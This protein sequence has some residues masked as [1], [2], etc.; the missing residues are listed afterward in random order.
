M[1]FNAHQYNRPVLVFGAGIQCSREQARAFAEKLGWP[2]ALTWGAIDLLPSSHELR[3][4]GFGTHALR[5]PNFAVQNADFL[6]CIGTRLDTKSTGTPAESF[7]RAADIWMVDIDVAEI[8]KFGQRVTGWNMDCRDFMNQFQSNQPVSAAWW[9][10][11]RR[12]VMR[13]PVSS[14]GPYQHVLALSERFN[15]GDIIVSDT[16]HALAWCMQAFQFK[17]NQRFIHAFNN[18]PMGYGLPAAIGAA[19]ANPGVPVRLITGDGGLQLNIQEW[20][21][22]AHHRLPITTYL[23]NNHGHGMCR[24]TQRQWMGGAFPSTSEQGGLACPDF[25]RIADAY[26]VALEEFILPFD[27]ELTPCV[28]SGRPNEDANPLIPR[29]ELESEMLIPLWKN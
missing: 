4:G 18:T 28:Q 2:V 10:A 11:I 21:T 27:S 7:A 23:F 26:G 16:G 20:S 25:R 13:W 12:W 14:F 24:Q 17:E 9:A 29:D 15:E 6:L 5:A 3:L 1:I 22:V 19:F 8:A